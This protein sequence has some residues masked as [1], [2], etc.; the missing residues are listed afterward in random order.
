MPVPHDLH[1]LL[2]HHDTGEPVLS[3]GLPEGASA[4]AERPADLPGPAYLWDEGGDP[5]DL[6]AQRWGVIAPE[7]PAGDR[8]LEIARPL[9]DAR[10]EAQGGHEI[11]VFR[12]PAKL[13]MAGASRWRK[14]VFDRGA[15][16]AVDLPRYQ[17]ILGDLDEV[18][19]AIQQVQGG[20]GYVGRLAFPDARGY[21]AYIHKLLRA[22]RHPS[23][24]REARSLFYTVH[25]GTPATA[26]GHKALVAPGTE[27]AR[28]RQGAGQFPAREILEL[29]SPRAPSPSE[30]LDAVSSPDPGVLFTLSHGAGAPA[31]GWR[32]A[33]EQREG[34]GAM[35]FGKEGRL[36]GR[37]LGERP[38]LPGGVWFMLACYGGGTPDSS[39]YRHWLERLRQAGEFG[40]EATAVLKALPRAAPFI[41]ALPRTALANPD[42]PLAF[43]GHIDL[44]WTYS[45][46]E[47]DGG[48]SP[49]ARPARFVA[50]LRS[51]LRG[52]RAGVAFRELTRAFQQANLE[53]T[54]LYDREAQ[55]GAHTRDNARLGH[56]WMLRQDL[57]GYVLLGD[58]A[59]RLPL[60]RGAV[61][62]PAA[63]PAALATP[64]AAPSAPATPP[65]LAE[66][67]PLEL[68]TLEEAIG[69]VLI[70]ERSTKEIAAE[71]K[72]DLGLL[73]RLADAY[74]K[75]GR[76]ALGRQ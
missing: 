52:D 72:L 11:K 54:S 59:A 63:T 45:F 31:E 70:R 50:V 4:P 73:K 20:D 74:R 25:D 19:L 61:A 18:P 44:A 65:A 21:E 69:H 33:S 22:E 76:A 75:G 66:E 15:D 23:A 36:A 7:G 64:A 46:E 8:L 37:D 62:Q 12:A 14:E 32:S 24:A 43:V 34:Q 28:R 26:L 42:G 49:V 13:D 30:L 35:M 5:G 10:R 57:A 17:L 39:A 27:L 58:P 56:L 16:L 71:Y 6:E 55:L 60:A 68:E 2:S 40:G 47:R 41:A 48:K 51:L 29:G 38:F 1:L 67:L 9:L 53:L 3:Q